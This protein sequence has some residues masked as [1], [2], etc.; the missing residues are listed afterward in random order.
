[1]ILQP[2]FIVFDGIDRAGKT[3]LSKHIT[4]EINA[5]YFGKLPNMNYI[6]QI[7]DPLERFK[8]CWEQ[9]KIRSK[10]I[11]KSLKKRHVI[12]DRYFLSTL[13]FH[14]ILTEKRL[15]ETVD[16]Y[17]LYQP[18]ITFLI[19]ADRQAIEKRFEQRPAEHKYEK[20][21]DFLMKV[22]E[23]FKRLIEIYNNIKQNTTII[24]TSNETIYD[25]LQKIKQGLDYLI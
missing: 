5:T 10:E 9:N 6:N 21:I 13:A 11:I 15:E 22:Q 19:T 25:S 2:K 18:D 23:E 7:S 14:N 16:I 1:M 17:D 4:E 20:D 3:T 8:H 12:S 24:D